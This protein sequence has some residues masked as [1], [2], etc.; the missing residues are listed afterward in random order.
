MK[1]IILNKTTG[2]SFLGNDIK[3]L[4]YDQ[5]WNRKDLPENIVR[6]RNWEEIVNIM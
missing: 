6:V 5:P 3:V 4:V 1:K 2:L